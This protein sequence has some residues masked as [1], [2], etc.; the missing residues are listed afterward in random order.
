MGLIMNRYNELVEI[1][2]QANYDYHVLD[3]PKITDQEYDNYLREIYEIEE[4]NPGIVR[5]DSPTKKVGGIVL[6]KF[7]KVTHEIPMMS[8]S[9]VFNEEEITLFDNRIKKEGI[10]PEYVCE[11]K[12]DGL[13]VSLKYEKGKFVRAATRGDGV[14]GEDITHNVLTIK[15]LPLKLSKEIDIE[16]RGEIFMSKKTLEKINKERE[17]KGEALLKNAR[18]A[19]AGSIRQLDSSVAAK[20]NLDMF[21]YHIPNPSDFGLNTHYEALEFLK[22]LGFKTNVNNKLVNNISEVFEFIREKGEIRESLPYGIDGVVIKLNNISEQNKMGYTARYPK[23]AT[24]Y[25][26]PAQETYTLLRDIVF[27]VGR[28][29]LVTPNA[30]LEPVMVMG[31]L[32][33]RATLHNEDYCNLKDIRIGDT[34]S[35]IKAGDVIPRVESVLTERRTGKERPFVMI[36]ECPICLT[37]LKKKEAQTYCPNIHCPARKIEALVHFVS[38]K[39]MNIDGLGENIIEDFYNMGIIKNIGDIYDLKKSREKLIELEGFGNKSVQKLLDSIEASKSN[40]LERVLFSLGIKGVGEK[41]AKI[42]AKK[43]LNIDNLMKASVEELENIRDLG[44]ILAHNI[45]TYFKNEDNLCI[46]EDLRAKGLNFIY[47][48]PVVLENTNFVGRKFVITGTLESYKRDQL[49]SLIESY[50]GEVVKSVSKNTDVVIA[51]EKSGSKFDKAKEL[52]I[53]IWDEEKL[54]LMLK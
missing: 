39:C 6:E 31:S 29:G 12:I 21:I 51:G 33:S 45:Y 16:V 4:K 46:I 28:T 10:N 37:E 41:V 15:T 14:V 13:S 2:N 11:L 7:V 30:V 36:K 53:E 52:D 27:T 8:L 32:V 34:V 38:R 35:I 17:Q 22:V 9:D 50:G 42:L 1:V 48:G 18:N 47:T 19:A 54:L 43:Y 25:K 5:D 26:F 44:P 24:A 23:W 20:R 40:S 3:D 49:S